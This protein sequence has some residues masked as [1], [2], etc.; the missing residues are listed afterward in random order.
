MQSIKT[1]I[2][3]IAVILTFI[4][5]IPYT[6]DII[7]GKTKP[8][9]YSWF[10]WGFVTAIV[11]ALQFNDKAGIGSFVTLAAAL[12]CFVVIFLAIKRRVTS[13]ITNSD[14]IFLGLAFLTL[15]IWL[16]AKQPLLSAILATAIDLL[17]FAPTVRKSWNEPYSE[18]L[19]FYYL[20]TLR[21]ALAAFSLNRYTIITALYPVLWFLANGLFAVILLVRRK[22]V[23]QP[24]NK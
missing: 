13:K 5:Y 20:N 6:R 21:F 12:M 9:L 18:T 24:I 17:G 1:I 7:A 14:K 4:G 2:G 15:A 11:F 22:Q 8:H 19:S 10:L 3:S 23:D 16:I